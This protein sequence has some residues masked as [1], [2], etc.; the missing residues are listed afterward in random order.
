MNTIKKYLGIVWILLA[1][2]VIYFLLSSAIEHIDSNK[3]G[4]IN[5]PVIWIII[6]AIF[7]PIAIGLLVFG[8]YALKGE[9]DH[10]PER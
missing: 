7:T 9:Y 3:K 4:Q 1:P 6:L 2:T 5:D 10:L 8:W